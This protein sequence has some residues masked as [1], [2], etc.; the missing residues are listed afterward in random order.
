MYVYIVSRIFVAPNHSSSS[1]LEPGRAIHR[2][3]ALYLVAG[4]EHPFDCLVIHNRPAMHSI[5]EFDGWD[6]EGQH[7]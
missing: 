4:V 7:V 3:V 2:Y 6:S 5:K 1:S